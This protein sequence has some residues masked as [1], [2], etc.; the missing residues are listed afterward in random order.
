MILGSAVLRTT[1]TSAEYKQ[2]ASARL[3][4]PQVLNWFPTLVTKADSA[5]IEQLRAVMAGHRARPST[6][7][8]LERKPRKAWMPATRAAMTA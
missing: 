6:S 8:F 5:Y 2:F 1:P 7:C 4:E 3:I